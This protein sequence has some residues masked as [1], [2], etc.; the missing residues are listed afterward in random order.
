MPTLVTITL[1]DETSERTTTGLHVTTPNIDGS[2]YAALLGGVA[3]NRAL[4]ITGLELLTKL[5]KT[6]VSAN[7]LYSQDA[8]DPP[9]DKTA[10]RE[11]V[12]R[13][14]AQDEV[15]MKKFIYTLGGP[16][17]ALFE[18]GSD[19]IDPDNVAFAAWKVVYEANAVSPD[20]N[21]CV[22][23]GGYRSGRNN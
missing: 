19:V 18:S 2:D 12:V 14:Q 8:D 13:F 16:V 4:L 20:G 9:S 10:Q 6:K 15:N 1:L 23:L 22:L 5:Q 3:S 17:D 11:Y 21:A 7:I